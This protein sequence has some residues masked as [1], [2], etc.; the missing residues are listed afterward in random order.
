MHAVSGQ[1]VTE[2]QRTRP[3]RP[4]TTPRPEDLHTTWRAAVTIGAIRADERERE[5]QRRSGFVLITTVPAK[6]L[7][8]AALL[9]EYKGQVH[10]ERH[11]HFL[12]DLLFVDALYVQKPERIEALGY[13]LLLACL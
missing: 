3:G 4:R 7:S 2:I 13:V 11:F 9:A 1:V 10:G 8:A 5:L 12:K 6:V